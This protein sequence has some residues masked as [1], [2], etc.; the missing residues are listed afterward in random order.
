MAADAGMIP[1]TGNS[2]LGLSSIRLEKGRFYGGR[3]TFKGE[4]PVVKRGY[5]ARRS[6]PENHRHE[7]L[8]SVGGKRNID[9]PKLREPDVCFLSCFWPAAV[10]C[11]ETN[12]LFYASEIVFLVWSC[13]F[14]VSSR[15]RVFS[16]LEVVLTADQPVSNN[17]ILD[18]VVRGNDRY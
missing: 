11:N 4:T 5:K 10:A 6:H 12:I 8:F 3:L 15:P 17:C 9:L 18:I 13:L 16:D 1:P 7:R 14:D 2:A